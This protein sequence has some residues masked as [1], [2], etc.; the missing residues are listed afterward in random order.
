MPFFCSLA[1]GASC[2]HT[3]TPAPRIRFD[4]EACKHL[5]RQADLHGFAGP[6]HA[7]FRGAGDCEPR[8][9]ARRKGP[10]SEGT[11]GRGGEGREACARASA[12]TPVHSRERARSRKCARTRKRLGEGHR[13]GLDLGAKTEQ[14]ESSLLE[15]I[16]VLPRGWVRSVRGH[17]LPLSLVGFGWVRRSLT[18]DS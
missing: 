5:T 14:T 16:L 1:L 6:R 17:Q 9:G 7:A 15:C 3:T 13:F 8:G 11:W 10:S 2:A 4:A 18:E 12:L